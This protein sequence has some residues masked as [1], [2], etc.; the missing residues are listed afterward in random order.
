MGVMEVNR[1]G[2][3]AQ[4][5]DITGRSLQGE[6]KEGELVVHTTLQPLA[7]VPALQPRGISHPLLKYRYLG[8]QL[9]R[10]CFIVME[11]LLFI[12]LPRF[13]NRLAFNKE[14]EH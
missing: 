14:N 2:W 5:V 6:G 10:H 7:K 1:K 3:T 4:R 12:F 8:S 9:E 13:C 11:K